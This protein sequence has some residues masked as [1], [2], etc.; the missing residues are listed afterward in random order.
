MQWHLK[1]LIEV[2]DTDQAISESFA[3]SSVVPH[4]QIHDSAMT[5]TSP[6]LTSECWTKNMLASHLGHITSRSPPCFSTLRRLAQNA[7]KSGDGSPSTP[8]SSMTNM[9]A[10]L[11]RGQNLVSEGKISP[12][13]LNRVPPRNSVLAPHDLHFFSIFPG[14]VTSGND[15]YS[16]TSSRLLLTNLHE[17][18][19]KSGHSRFFDKAFG[20]LLGVRN[21]RCPFS[22]EA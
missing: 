8:R 2:F 1:W 22:I 11:H 19:G 7:G 5:L 6:K 14:P 13:R 9:F 17:G 3:V 4:S 12:P 10:S 20:S 15:F 21:F 18:A 16:S